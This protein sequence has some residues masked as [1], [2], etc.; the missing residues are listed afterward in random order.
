MVANWDSMSCYG[1]PPGEYVV[2]GLRQARGA[3]PAWLPKTI[4]VFWRGELRFPLGWKLHISVRDAD[5]DRLARL[6]LPTLRLM[7]VYHK[8]IAPW[9]DYAAFN[10]DSQQRGK[11]ITVYPGPDPNT[12][13]RVLDTLDALF[14]REGFV[15][16]PLPSVRRTGHTT[17]EVPVGQ[18]GMFS[19]LWS[20]DYTQ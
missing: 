17:H 3:V 16:G 15:P 18:S 6:A 19:C 11:F 14:R 2:N 8:V 7:N 4:F 5:A 1:Q 12:A 10:R 13:Q 9:E 20:D